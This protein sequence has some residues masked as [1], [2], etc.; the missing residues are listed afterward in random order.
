MKL[1]FT[2]KAR[3]GMHRLEELQPAASKKCN[4]DECVSS[5]AKGF[6]KHI[7]SA[8]E[9]ITDDNL[10]LASEEIECLLDSYGERVGDSVD[11]MHMIRFHNAMGRRKV[12]G[13]MA[14]AEYKKRGID[15]PY[16][17]LDHDHYCHLELMVMLNKILENIIF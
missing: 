14:R 6:R 2:V 11:S 10:K 13:S 7:L 8:H 5:W 4:D 9:A 1:Y 3:D 15:N 12:A 17:L 16:P